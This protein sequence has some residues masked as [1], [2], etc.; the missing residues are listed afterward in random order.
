MTVVDKLEDAACY[1]GLELWLQT[2]CRNH[3]LWAYDAEH[4]DF[5]ER[6]VRAFI[7]EREPNRN[8]SLASRLPAWLKDAKNR[9]LVLARCATLRVRLHQ[10]SRYKVDVGQRRVTDSDLM[11]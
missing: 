10:A 5:L 2:P 9:D 8:G 6:Y 1:A 7:R 4:L 3:V 11:R